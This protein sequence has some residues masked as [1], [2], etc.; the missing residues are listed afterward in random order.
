LPPGPPS[1]SP[2]PP[3]PRPRPADTA[4]VQYE[5]DY[6]RTTLPPSLEP[7]GPPGVAGGFFLNTGTCSRR[8]DRARHDSPEA[9]RRWAS[10]WRF[11]PARS[12]APALARRLPLQSPLKK[13]EKTG[14]FG[15]AASI[16]PLARCLSSTRALPCRRVSP[17]QTTP[18]RATTYNPPAFRFS[19]FNRPTH[20]RYNVPP[21]AIDHGFLS[22]YSRLYA[23]P[24]PV[25]PASRPRFR[26]RAFRSPATR[27]SC[28]QPKLVGHT[29]SA[30]FFSSGNRAPRSRHP[31]LGG[32]PRNSEARRP[33]A[34]NQPLPRPVSEAQS[35]GHTP[36]CSRGAAASGRGPRR[37]HRVREG[38]TSLTNHER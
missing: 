36:T 10:L 7:S 9:G 21:R 22:R 8:L 31:P 20:A 19:P 2:E 11:G 33:P 29:G 23:K 16:S 35:P 5:T 32:V 38:S 12:V 26:S 13:P 30:S 1:P 15:P 14:T 37:S 4:F 18:A 25:P 27:P 3:F 24:R 6:A 28:S 17:Q 34:T